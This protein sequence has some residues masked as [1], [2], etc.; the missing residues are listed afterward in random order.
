VNLIGSHGLIKEGSED[1]EKN[2]NLSKAKKEKNDE[3]Y[4]QYKDIEKEVIHY[5]DQLKGKV[6]YCNCD[7]PEFSN[8]WFYFKDHFVELG[9]K[10]L[11]VT[12]YDTNK[13]VYKLYYTGGILVYKVPLKGNGD[14]RSDECIEILKQSDV[15]ITNPPFSKFRNYIAQLMEYDKKF[16]VIGNQNAITYKEIFMLLKK[17]E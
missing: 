10:K 16:L 8:F 1:M 14:F 3:F 13:P 15:V 11:I 6:V 4:T 9:L 12:F 5:K 7:D 2:K 17:K